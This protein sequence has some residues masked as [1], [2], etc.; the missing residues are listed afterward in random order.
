MSFSLNSLPLVFPNGIA[1]R[2]HLA[3]V[4]AIRF[5]LIRMRNAPRF[6]GKTEFLHSREFAST[7]WRAPN[8]YFAAVVGACATT[9]EG[10]SIHCQDRMDRR[11][12]E[13]SVTKSSFGAVKR[14]TNRVSAAWTKITLFWK[15]R[16]R[17]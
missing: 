2:R 9:D 14:K 7:A 4:G 1:R 8:A 13:W 6:P 11:K 15:V 16:P 12:F 10:P 3:W 5:L 17:L